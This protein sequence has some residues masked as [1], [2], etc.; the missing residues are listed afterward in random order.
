MAQDLSAPGPFA[1]GWTDLT[2]PRPGGGSF[3]AKLFYPAV[4]RGENATYDGSGAPYPAI[5][6]GHGFLQ[7]VEQYQ[8]TLEHLATWGY[9]AIASRSAGGLF[10]NH[11][12]FANDMRYCLDWLEQQNGDTGSIL[13]GQVDTQRFGMSGHSMGGGASLL[14][15]ATD[16]RVRTVANMAAANTNPSAID[17]AGQITVPLCL[18]TGSQDSIVPPANHGQLMYNAAGPPK[19]LPLIVGGFHCGFTDDGFLFC[20]S[21]SISRSTQLAITRRLLVA[22]FNLYLKGDQSLWPIVW[23]EAMLADPQVTTTFDAGIVLTPPATTPV[24]RG[25]STIDVDVQITNTDDQSTSYTMLVE[26]NTWP[27]T[28]TPSQTPALAPNAATSIPLQV[29]LPAAPG[30]TTDEFLFTARSDADNATRTF[31]RFQIDKTN[32][33]DF[34]LD[35]DIDEVDLQSFVDCATG[36]AIPLVPSCDP[37]D[38]DGDDDADNSDFAT[39]QRCW[40]GSGVAADPNCQ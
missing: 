7:S 26:D 27:V 5:S 15:T 2:V 4:T 22:W 8:S 12:N 18:I 38:L 3:T 34:D 29:S 35:R 40:S 39:V 1:A 23:G 19:Q 9:L 16:P 33:A 25:G 30:V 14:A 28:I 37:F 20:D 17:A 32:P 36:P 10:P 11:Q 6:F 21:G 31:Y 13:F 24:G